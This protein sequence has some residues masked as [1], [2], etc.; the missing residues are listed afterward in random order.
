MKKR[1]MMVTMTALAIG[2][3]SGCGKDTDTTVTT[4]APTETAATPTE[5]E[6]TPT[7]AEATTTDTVSDVVEDVV[8]DIVYPG[9]LPEVKELFENAPEY[10][11]VVSVTGDLF[12]TFEV[13]N[14]GSVWVD[15]ETGYIYA[16]SDDLLGSQIAY[17]S[18]GEREIVGLA[19][20]GEMTTPNGTYK[21]PE[22]IDDGTTFGMMGVAI[23]DMTTGEQVDFN[24]NTDN[25]VF[26]YVDKYGITHEVPDD[27]KYVSCFTELLKRGSATVEVQ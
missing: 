2:M 8:A 1:L 23:I 27:G 25:G 14:G 19:V 10:Y 26:R 3:L 12:G 4:A 21:N 17:F 11:D 13:T 6:A 15:E 9:I 20:K 16:E 18:D 24:F 7:E 5:A 22:T